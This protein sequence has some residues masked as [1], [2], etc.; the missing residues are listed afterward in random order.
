[1][2]EPLEYQ[3]PILRR[4]IPP[5]PT[6][7]FFVCWPG[8]IFGAAAAFLQIPHAPGGLNGVFEF[9]FVLAIPLSGFGVAT[10]FRGNLEDNWNTLGVAG[11]IALVLISAVFAIHCRS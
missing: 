9:W 2:P 4:R 10:G 11:N 6:V 5:I 8:T 3:T 7:L 1:M